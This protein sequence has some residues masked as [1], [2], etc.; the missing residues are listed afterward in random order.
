MLIEFLLLSPVRF[1]AILVLHHQEV[2]N[3]VIHIEQAFSEIEL[4]EISNF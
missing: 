2:E 4:K 3:R 1:L